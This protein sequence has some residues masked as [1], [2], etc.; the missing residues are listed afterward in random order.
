MIFLYNP[1]NV[2]TRMSR[3]NKGHFLYIGGGSR[4]ILITTDTKLLDTKYAFCGFNSDLIE[5][6]NCL[7]MHVLKVIVA[8][9][10]GNSFLQC[11]CY[12]VSK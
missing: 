5:T 1:W 2:L 8:M 7:T 12:F 6:I 11:K 10:H 3:R 4:V 9:L